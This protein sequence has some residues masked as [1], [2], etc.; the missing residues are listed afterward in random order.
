M[1]LED[2]ESV[3]DATLAT[4]TVRHHDVAAGRSARGT[5]AQEGSE[6]T[7]AARGQ[8]PLSDARVPPLTRAKIVG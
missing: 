6:S 5:R 1:P 2:P 4:A 7:R 8:R 3:T